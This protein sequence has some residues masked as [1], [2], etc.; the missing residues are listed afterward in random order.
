LHNVKNYILLLFIGWTLV[1]CNKQELEADIPAY[2]Y[3]NN[4]TLTTTPEQGTSSHKIT[5]AWVYLDQELLGV[6]ELPV[7]FPVVKEGSFKL[8]VYPGIKENGIAERRERYLFYNGYS[9][10]IQLEKEKTIE[11]NP[12]TTYTSGTTFYWMEDFESASLPF[13]YNVISDTVMNK[14]TS[15]VFE[16]SYA[17]EVVLT[18]LM[19]FFECNTP[20]FSTLPRF[21]SPVF[22][23]LNFKTNKPVLVGLYADSEQLGLFYLNT[24]SSWNKIYLNF[25]EAIQTRPASNDYKIFFGF[26]N[27]LQE[28]DFKIDNLKLIHL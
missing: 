13:L 24:S 7:R 3:I 15:D 28:P 16:G 12:T 23:E 25:T 8:E 14:T 19:D 5:D 6:F 20:G 10:Q 9:K 22:L 18:P 26:Q 21:G 1:S 4:F 11:I 27:N 2:I 17:G